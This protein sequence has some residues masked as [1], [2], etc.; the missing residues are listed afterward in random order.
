MSIPSLGEKTYEYNQIYL[1]A[2]GAMSMALAGASRPDGVKRLFVV[3][4]APQVGSPP[5]QIAAT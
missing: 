5:V 1:G 3:F 4:C 2:E